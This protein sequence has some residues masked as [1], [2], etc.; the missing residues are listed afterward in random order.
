MTRNTNFFDQI[1]DYFFG[2]LEGESKLEFEA[3]LVKNPELKL[4]LELWTEIRS[5]LKE[6][7]VLNLRNKLENVAKDNK[8][9]VLGNESFELLTDLS[10]FQEMS[11]ILSPE[12]LINF[13]DSLPR[14]HAYHHVATQ[15][16]N[17]HH[18]YK[19]QN[20]S[21]VKEVEDDFNDFDLA[22]FEGL[23]EAILEKDILQFRQT[24]KQVAK[25]V[26]PQFSVE[27]I[28][29][30]IHGELSG[31]E[32]I[33]FERDLRQSRIL[34]DEVKLHADI[35]M[36]IQENEIISLRSQ[37]SNILQTETSWSVSEENIED[38]IDGE[39]EGELLEEF[40]MELSENSDLMAEIELRRQIN[41]SIGEKDI[42]NLRNELKSVKKSSEAKKLKMLIPEVNSGQIKFLRRGVAV[43]VILLGLAGVLRNSFVSA[44]RTYESFYESPGWSPERSLTNELSL[45][46]E[47]QN[48]YLDGNHKQVVEILSTKAEENKD[49][50]VFGFYLAAS[51]QKL[52]KLEE[53]I[54][55]YSKVINQGDNQYI[56]EAEWY[57][58]LCY[59]GLG[60]LN[61]AKK[62]LIAVIDKKGY[63]KDDAKAV[64]RRLKYSIK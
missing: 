50:P 11:E 54:T 35:E 46:Q 39:L 42:M 40:K 7:E 56:E 19:K 59:L 22:G 43:L 27:E 62:E 8:P 14:V 13:Y 41:A 29:N 38:F 64:I 26:E 9:E 15:N 2:Q 60:N 37:I 17:I 36:S 49:Y 52:G 53:A 63:Y 10:E 34:Q 57:R 25:S 16:E 61:E 24:L 21:V 51:L 5:A 55:E 45:L 47:A 18:F 44:D 12:E 3:E 6:K 30:Y 4:E 31:S 28:D 48:L 1:E 58:S 33:S 23:E 32:L 20:G